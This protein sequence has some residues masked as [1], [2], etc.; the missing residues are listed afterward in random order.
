MLRE[1]PKAPL[2]VRTRMHSSRM[3]TVCSSSRLLGGGEGGV[4]LSA[5]W[6]THPRAWVWTPPGLG[7][8]PLGMG[9]NP[10]RQ[11]PQPTLGPGPTPP[12]ADPQPPPGP[13]PRHP[14]QTPNLPP[15]P[16][17]RHPP[18]NRMTDRCKN[19]TFANFVCGR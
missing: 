15:G 12:R 10:R 1:S 11:T 17:P 3:R 5:W 6:H 13:G 18:V 16:G 9:L 19:I 7:L 2:T 8:D 14:P 4:C